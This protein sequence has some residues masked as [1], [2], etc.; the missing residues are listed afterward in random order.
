MN[1]KER[2][3]KNVIKQKGCWSWNGN[4]GKTYKSIIYNGK[5]IKAHRA[6][7]M[8]YKGSIPDGMCVCHKC[9]NPICTNPDHL[10]LGTQQDNLNDMRKKRLKREK[11]GIYMNKNIY[12]NNK[13]R[14]SME[15]D[16]KTHKE[17][18]HICIN[19]NITLKKLVLRAVAKLIR[20]ENSVNK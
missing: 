4:K 7:W 20:E 8:L 13:V 14:L 10:F 3:E 1:N 9:D 18:K 15:I 12:S 2:F 17:L 5:A 16:T 6:S 19:R 11:D